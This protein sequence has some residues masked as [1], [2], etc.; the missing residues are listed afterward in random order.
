MQFG[1]GYVTAQIPPGDSRTEYGRY[2]EEIELIQRAEAV[3]FDSVWISEE[4][5]REDRYLSSPVPFCGALAQ[6]TSRLTIGTGIALAPLYD[7]LRLAEEAATIDLLSGGR[8]Q[9]GIGIGYRDYEFEWFDA[10]KSERVP[11]TIDAIEV[12]RRG[13]T[14][15]RFSYDGRASSYK[16]VLVTPTPLQGSDL[17]IIY[18]AQSEPAA[19]RAGRLGDGIA[20]LHSHPR[21]EVEDLLRW[22]RAEGGDRED[23][24]VILVR[25]VAVGDST[26]A[27]WNRME[28]GSV[29]VNRTYAAEYEE[30]SDSVEIPEA[31]TA[32]NAREWGVYGTPDEVA[33]ELEEYADLL[34]D[35]DHLVA[36]CAFPT[37]RQAEAMT[38]VERFGREVIPRVRST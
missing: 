38:A 29:Y 30:S 16:D 26:E 13:W 5:G 4:H 27:A 22:C 1:L 11:R 6:A 37:M 9:L 28:P 24:S 12:C 35:D 19:R 31:D 20:I 23:F 14:G 2:Q 18:A 7:P 32:N 21:E 33:A 8:F 15:E 3:G 10:P 25:E 36:R 17:P 34:G